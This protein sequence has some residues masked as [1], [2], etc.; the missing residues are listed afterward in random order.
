MSYKTGVKRHVENLV[1]H[2]LLHFLQTKSF[3]QVN[4]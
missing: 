1:F 2:C 4:N 3:S